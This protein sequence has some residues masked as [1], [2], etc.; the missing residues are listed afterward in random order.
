MKPYCFENDEKACAI[1][2]VIPFGKHYREK[3]TDVINDAKLRDCAIVGAVL[4][5]G[6][7]LVSE[8]RRKT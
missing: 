1:L 5:L 2:V 8:I 4:I 7:A 6:A 3:I